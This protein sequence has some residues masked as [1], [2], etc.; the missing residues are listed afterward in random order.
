MIL[1]AD[2]GPIIALAK[3]NRLDLLHTL[4]WQLVYIPPIVRKEL[5]SKWGNESEAIEAALDSF[6]KVVS[7]KM[8]HF[9]SEAFLIE[10]GDGEKQVI[11]LGI[12][13]EREVT[14][15][16]D[17]LA[18]RRAAQK[19]A[20]P[21]IGTGGVLLMAK[22]GGL[23]PRITPLLEEIRRCG[24]WLSDELIAYLKQVAGE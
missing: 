19:L 22:K 21:I 24:Y 3:I 11:R 18:A 5:L 4:I 14:L 17:D 6:L 15:L 23:I 7:P 13:L 12:S 2:T 20:I 16:L 10:L 9:A 1:I 8:V